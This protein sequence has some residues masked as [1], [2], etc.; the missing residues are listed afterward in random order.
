VVKVS[1]LD[2]EIAV[3]DEASGLATRNAHVCGRP[4]RLAGA[5]NSFPAVAIS[6]ALLEEGRDL[7]ELLFTGAEQ[8]CNRRALLFEFQ[9][10]RRGQWSN[11]IDFDQPDL[12]HLPCLIAPWGGRVSL[13]LLTIAKEML[14]PA[15]VQTRDEHGNWLSLEES[16][17]G[18]R[19]AFTIL[20]AAAKE[21]SLCMNCAPRLLWRLTSSDTV[22]SYK[23]WRN[24]NEILRNIPIP[25]S[26]TDSY[27]I[28]RFLNLARLFYRSVL[29]VVA[30]DATDTHKRRI[31]TVSFDGPLRVRKR[32]KETLGLTPRVIAPRAMF[33]GNARS[34]HLQILPSEK[35]TAVDSRLLY[36]YYASQSIELTDDKPLQHP[37]ELIHDAGVESVLTK[38]SAQ[39]WWGHIEGPAEPMSAHVRGSSARIPNLECGRESFGVF[40]LYPQFTGVLTQHMVTAITNFAFVASFVVGLQISQSLRSLLYDSP[41]VIFIVTVLVAGFG[42]GLTLYPKEHLLTS[43]VLRPWRRLEA[44]VVGL[45]LAIP[46]TSVA[47]WNKETMTVP[48]APLWVEFGLD[49]A[50]VAFFLLIT[51]QVWLTETNG[52]RGWRR[53]GMRLRRAGFPHFGQAIDDREIAR[54]ESDP[55]WAKWVKDRNSREERKLKI[56]EKRFVRKYLVEKSRND[57]FNRG[58]APST[59]HSRMNRSW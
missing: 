22:Q 47:R 7:I 4:K 52:G 32:L 39:Q 35:V 56:I 1:L 17:K 30:L 20:V 11:I 42:V 58:V 31:V 10:E 24:L 46:V 40:Q 37:D 33:G 6:Q 45:T 38:C 57:L 14:P 54:R 5:P 51:Y 50:V 27:V 26:T 41:E 44:L 9:Q 49:A 19:L 21:A 8:W 25:T 59:R 28:L 3:N 53:T 16:S 12:R 55:Q 43:A 36:S 34:Y 2:W 13:P 23:A 29:I 48:M 18:R 15:H